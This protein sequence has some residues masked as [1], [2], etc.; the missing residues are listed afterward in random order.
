[1]ASSFNIGDTFTESSQAKAEIDGPIE[2]EVYVRYN[3]GHI[4]SFFFVDEVCLLC[5]N[6]SVSLV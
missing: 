1:M 6:L 2:V 3:T 5:W 4:I